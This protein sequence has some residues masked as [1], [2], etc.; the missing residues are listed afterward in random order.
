MLTAMAITAAEY[1]SIFGPPDQLR[2][3]ACSFAALA[4]GMLIWRRGVVRGTTLVGPWA[5]FL[6]ALVG[7]TVGEIM[8]ARIGPTVSATPLRLLTA[9]L[10][11]CPPMSLSGAKRPQDKPWHIIVASLWLVLT[12]PA[13][14]NVMMHKTGELETHAARAWFLF[15]LLICG[16]LNSLFTRFWPC[17]LL[18]AV[19]Q[20]ILLS[21]YLPWPLK[22]LSACDSSWGV[23]SVSGAVIL[24]TTCFRRRRRPAE[25][26]DHLWLD[27]RDAFGLLWTLRV[28]EQINKVSRASGWNV[29][30]SWQGIRSHGQSLGLQEWPPDQRRAFHQSLCNLLRRFVNEEWI[31]A[32]LG[33]ASVS[34]SNRTV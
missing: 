17:V 28:A 7:T 24:A 34:D 19:G 5:W 23:M 6:V 22:A 9:A 1:G 25:P 4:A 21:P 31:A 8:A 26:L 13:L 15:T 18:A 30:A 27:F 14:Q 20:A 10:T 11:L 32:R 3:A 29:S 2:I 33:M 12:L 16:V